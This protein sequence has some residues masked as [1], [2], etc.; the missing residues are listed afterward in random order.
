MKY[1][2]KFRIGERYFKREVEATT[3]IWAE[4]QFFREI[5]VLSVDPVEEKPKEPEIIQ[6]I[7]E[8]QKQ[9]K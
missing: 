8:I 6:F 4:K 9:S 7:K 5:E 3:P 2:V 1:I